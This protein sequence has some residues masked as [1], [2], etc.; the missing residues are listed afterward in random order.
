MAAFKANFHRTHGRAYD[1]KLQPYYRT[2]RGK[3]PVKSRHYPSPRVKLTAGVHRRS[4]CWYATITMDTIKTEKG[5]SI[6]RLG[7]KGARLAATLQRMVWLIDHKIWKPDEGDPLKLIRYL[8][9]FQG[10]AEYVNSVIDDVANPWAA[11][12]EEF[13]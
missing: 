6:N 5:F 9:A 12:T 11:P 7:E 8:D 2:A 3:Q 13:V 1:V 4:G 10:N